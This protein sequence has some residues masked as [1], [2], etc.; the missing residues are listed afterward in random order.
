MLRQFKPNLSD[1]KAYVD[2]FFRT[3]LSFRENERSMLWENSEADRIP[4]YES[5]CIKITGTIYNYIAFVDDCDEV[6]AAAEY[7]CVGSTCNIVAFYVLREYQLRGVGRRFFRELVAYLKKYGI[8]QIN[9]FSF[10]Y[11]SMAFWKKMG[12]VENDTLYSKFLI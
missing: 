2:L 10:T 3:N 5:Y 6:I 12:F 7:T 1:Y 4:S 11:G 9:L 8:L